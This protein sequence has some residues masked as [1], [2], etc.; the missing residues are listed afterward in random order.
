MSLWLRLYTSILESH[1]LQTL[2]DASFR[3]VINLWCIAKERGGILPGADECAFRLRMKRQR[4][5]QLFQSVSS[6]FDETADGRFVPHDWSEHQ[7]ES[8]V[9]TKRVQR[10]RKRFMKR[11]E[12]VSE[13]PSETETETE[14]S[15]QTPKPPPADAG[16]FALDPPPERV[17]RDWKS[18]RFE[19]FWAVVWR[20][21]GKDDSRKS[22]MRKVTSDSM[23]E[24]VIEAAKRDGPRLLHE[25]EVQ[26]RSPIHPKTWLNQGRYDD[27][28]PSIDSTGTE[29]WP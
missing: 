21:I 15:R 3:L 25:A 8:D 10:F 26:Y 5:D 9:S 2:P 20:K 17:P 28:P 12:T 14:Q 1:K 23:A 13:T 19:E 27:E 16:L 22:F 29:D 18:Q 4:Y 7:Y 6:L 11:D 24:R